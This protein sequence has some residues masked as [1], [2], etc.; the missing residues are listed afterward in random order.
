MSTQSTYELSREH[1]EFRRTVRD[2][3]E[4]EIAPARRAVGP[5]A[6]LPGRR[7]AE[8]GRAG[9][10]RADLARGVRRRRRGRRLHQPV[11]RDRGDRPGRP[12]DGHHAR[13]RGR[14]RHQ[15]DPDLRHRRA[16]ADLAARPGRRRARWPASASPSPA[17]APTR[18]RPGPRPCSTTASGSS[19]APSSS[20]P[21]PAPRSPA[22]SPSPP[23]PATA[24][25][26]KPEISTIMV[27]ER[28]ARLHRREGLRQAR[29]ARLRH[30]PAHLRGRPRPRGQP[31]RRARPRL[32]PVP[33]HPRRRPGRDR[34]ARGRLHPGLPRPE[35]RVRRRAADLR[36][37]DR[38]QAGRRLPD[39][40]PRGDAA[41]Q[42]AADLPGRRDE[43]RRRRR[44]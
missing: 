15:P 40:R 7:R 39:R 25:D 9:P 17:P 14:P 18:A 5:R 32:R 31:A 38:P 33:R 28:H 10:V 26:G 24:S 43:G 12:V 2:F 11:R 3:A 13:G 35:P 19:T 16:E 44:R 27:P 21:T 36:R 30:P 29:L 4:A 8:D 23:A 34:R 37:P 42:P 20:S 41:R 1:E 6:P 22:S